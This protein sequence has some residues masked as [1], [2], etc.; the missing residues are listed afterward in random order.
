MQSRVYFTRQLVHELKTPLTSLMATSQL[1]LEET[2][3]TRLEKLAGYVFESSKN[4]CLRCMRMKN[5]VSH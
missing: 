2:H 5:E 1:L 3:N 4:L